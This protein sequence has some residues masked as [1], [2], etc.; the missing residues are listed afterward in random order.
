MLKSLFAASCFLALFGAASMAEDLT[1]K[2]GLYH[3]VGMLPAAVVASQWEHSRPVLISTEQPAVASGTSFTP[4]I[5]VPS[6][7][8]FSV[9]TPTAGLRTLVGTSWR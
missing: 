4:T 2:L 8:T 6:D 7:C 5:N 1:N 9:R 3:A